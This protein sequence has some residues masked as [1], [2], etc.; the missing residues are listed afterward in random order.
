[1]LYVESVQARNWV[2]VQKSVLID[3][4]VLRWSLCCYRVELLCPV[5]TRFTIQNK[6]SGGYPLNCMTPSGKLPPLRSTKGTK[7]MF[8][9]LTPIPSSE[10]EDDKTNVYQI[11]VS[12]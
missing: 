7:I 1:M 8:N 2:E 5:E 3:D 9:T 12:F 6:W 11:T 4:D 10:P